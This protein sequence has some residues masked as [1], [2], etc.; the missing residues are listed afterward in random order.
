MR[1]V[2][3]GV[4]RQKLRKTGVESQKLRGEERIHPPGNTESRKDVQ[5]KIWFDASENSGLTV[6]TALGRARLEDSTAQFQREIRKTSMRISNGGLT[7]R[8]Q[9]RDGKAGETR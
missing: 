8:R 7:R 6:E 2:S 1:D 3:C 9:S 5:S 4:M